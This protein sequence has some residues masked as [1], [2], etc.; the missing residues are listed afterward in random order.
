MVHTVRNLAAMQEKESEVTQLRL[1]LCDPADCSLPGSS[2][3]EILQARI[4]EWVAISFSRGSSRPRDRTRV[5]CI[6][7][8]HFTIWA[9]REVNNWEST[10]IFRHLTSIFW[11]EGLLTYGIWSHHFMANWRGKGRNS[12]RFYFGRAPKSLQMV[13]AAMKLK[14]TCSLE[15]KPWQA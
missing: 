12:D 6:G 3:R 5:S 9:N 13:T 10:A 4:L 7:V 8:R 11:N 14:D 15:E 1:T 2:V